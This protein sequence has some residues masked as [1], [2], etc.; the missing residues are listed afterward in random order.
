MRLRGTQVPRETMAMNKYLSKITV[1][2]NGLNAP[3]KR[4]R[5][6]EWIRRHDLHICSLQETHLRTTDLC[7]LKVKGW[8]KIFQANGQGKEGRVA[9]LISDKYTS[10]Q[11][12]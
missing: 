4:Q 3:T 7:R 9:I 8:V 12:P 10:K 2:V 5:V 1:S 6:A 11:R